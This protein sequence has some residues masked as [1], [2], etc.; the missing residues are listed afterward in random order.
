MPRGLADE[1]R[2]LLRGRHG[3]LDGRAHPLVHDP[4]V[5]VKDLV[6]LREAR[7]DGPLRLEPKEANES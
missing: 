5:R 7:V 6:D 2:L 1:E 3:G 4:D